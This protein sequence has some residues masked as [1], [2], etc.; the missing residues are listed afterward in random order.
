M[1]NAHL[2]K[3]AVPKLVNAA[4]LSNRAAAP[5]GLVSAVGL[6]VESV[7]AGGRQFPVLAQSQIQV[8]FE[9]EPSQLQLEVNRSVRIGLS[10]KAVSPA[11][12]VDRDGAPL[13]LDP[14]TGMMLDGTQ[15]M[16]ARS[17]LQLLATGLGRVTPDWPS[18][19]PA[20]SSNVPV[21]A[22]SV[23]AFLNGTPVEVVKATLAPGYVGMYLVEIRLP[24]VLDAGA[25]DLYLT[26][27]GETSNHVLLSVSY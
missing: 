16:Q 17:S 1:W 13:L 12:F 24:A 21:V 7:S 2:T 9:T 23:Q 25:A 8:P 3:L 15:P 6:T 11:V 14:E 26:A 18:G 20:P 22:A 10:V 27:A 4:D 5:G 19:V